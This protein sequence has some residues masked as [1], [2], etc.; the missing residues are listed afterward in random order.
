[1]VGRLSVRCSL[2]VLSVASFSAFAAG[3]VRE[4]EARDYMSAYGPCRRS[5][6]L[7]RSRCADV[8][9]Q[10]RGARETERQSSRGLRRGAGGDDA[11]RTRG[12]R[13]RR[14]EAPRARAP[15]HV[16][17]VASRGA[18]SARDSDRVRL[19]HRA[20]REVD[21]RQHDPAPRLVSSRRPAASEGIDLLILDSF[22]R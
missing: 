17:G 7:A 2:L 20:V 18:A 3:Y 21:A 9:H 12:V 15:L 19:L 13:E 1:M 10:I 14:R 4:R 8:R 11:V 16:E 5:D 22:P 6:V